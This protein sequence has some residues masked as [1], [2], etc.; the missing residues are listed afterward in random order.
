MKIF[1]FFILVLGLTI[2]ASAL[3]NYKADELAKIF[4]KINTNDSK[5]N[6]IIWS[7]K[8][9]NLGIGQFIWYS[10]QSSKKYNETFPEFISFL[11]KKTSSNKIPHEF[12]TRFKNKKEFIKWKNQHKTRV[13]QLEDW[14]TSKKMMQYQTLF[15]ID[16]FKNSMQKI[17]VDV[18]S[19]RYK[20]FQAMMRV[21]AGH[22][23]F[24]MIDYMNFKG[25]GLSKRERYNNQGWGIVQ[26]LD[27]MNTKSPD[28]VLEFKNKAESLLKTRIKNHPSDKKYFKSWKNHLNTYKGNQ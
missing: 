11:K 14:L 23:L 4:Y 26:V 3:S 24:I 22:G 18:D 20:N 10:N 13:N 5:K 12:L 1:N 8:H 6:T 25:T 7:G 19:N 21:K 16:K 28:T 27:L 2:S 9:L 17:L 15:I